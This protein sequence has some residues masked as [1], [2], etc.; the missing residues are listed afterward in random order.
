[1]H[2]TQDGN[3][4]WSADVGMR[5]TFHG[6]D[7]GEWALLDNRYVNLLAYEREGEFL[8]VK[9]ETAN[10]LVLKCYDGTSDEE[11]FALVNPPMYEGDRRMMAYEDTQPGWISRPRNAIALNFGMEWSVIS[12]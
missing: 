3:D 6:K 11:A 4:T 2:L 10:A 9:N 8:I 12:G 7:R 1:M 5:V